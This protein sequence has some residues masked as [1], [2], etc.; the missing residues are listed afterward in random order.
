MKK[1]CM[2]SNC[3]RMFYQLLHH[4]CCAHVVKSKQELGFLSSQHVKISVSF[5]FYPGVLCMQI[6]E[7]TFL[8]WRGSGPMARHSSW[9]NVLN[10]RH[11]TV[12]D[13][14]NCCMCI[15]IYIFYQSTLRLQ[16]GAQLIFIFCSWHYVGDAK[17]K[18][19]LN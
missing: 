2:T 15:I 10:A 6:G 4:F 3:Q 8:A 7:L 9:L 19:S 18:D 11:C 1:W 13:D 5:L 12:K 16:N 14:Y 17:K